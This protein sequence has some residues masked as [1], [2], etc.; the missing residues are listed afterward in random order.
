MGNRCQEIRLDNEWLKPRTADHSAYSL[1]DSGLA[2]PNNNLN[3][4]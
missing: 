3:L 1:Q 4:K 2:L